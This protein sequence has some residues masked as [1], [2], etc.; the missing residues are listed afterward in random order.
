M[1]YSYL[2]LNIW[3]QSSRSWGF[4]TTSKTPWNFFYNLLS[5]MIQKEQIGGYLLYGSRY[6][7]LQIQRLRPYTFRDTT[8][9]R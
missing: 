3:Y 6:V 9:V 7:G 1:L 4:A 5:T 2:F 8:F